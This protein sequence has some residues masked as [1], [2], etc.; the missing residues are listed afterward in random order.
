LE[1]IEVIIFD[2]GSGDDYV[3][4]IYLL[5]E[6][7]K[8]KG[9]NKIKV[10]SS[11]NNVGLIKARNVLTKNVN[12]NSKFLLF[13]DDDI[14]I[15]KDTINILVDSIL[16]D[17]EIGVVGP[18]I[19]LHKNPLIVL[20]SANFLNKWTGRYYAINSEHL[21]ECDWIEPGCMLVRKEVIT[22]INGFC[23]DFYRS[24]EGVDFCL[25][26][27]KIGY[28]IVYNPYAVVEHDVGVDKL[29]PER[30]YYIYRNKIFIIKKHLT[31]L[32][33]VLSIFII[34]FFGLPIYI[35]NSF[36]RNRKFK[37]FEIRL[38]IEAIIDGILDIKGKLY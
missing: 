17:N 13:L 20:Q 31:F 3:K 2:D 32:G 34:L 18:K 19:L 6:K 21:L 12:E 26:V 36:I 7:I 16:R 4:E 28:K 33:K 9:L 30:L 27:R 25:R 14:Y 11:S 37:C 5:V 38:I 35:L 24:H 15:H 29:T 1:N 8:L 22:K 10:I 23:E